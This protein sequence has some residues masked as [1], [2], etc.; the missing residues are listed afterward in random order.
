[1]GVKKGKKTR[2]F[3]SPH[4]LQSPRYLKIS[5]WSSTR[6][7]KNGIGLLVMQ[8]TDFKAHDPS[9]PLF[10]LAPGEDLRYLPYF[11][12]Y[13]TQTPRNGLVTVLSAGILATQHHYE[14]RSSR[15]PKT[16]IWSSTQYKAPKGLDLISS[17]SDLA[18][19]RTSLDF[20]R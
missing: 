2:V 9:K 17:H 5:I 19:K 1:M 4:G 10:G 16:S 11:T 14:L 12:V 7:Q 20:I 15:H 3:I 8:S 13:R 18:R 6:D